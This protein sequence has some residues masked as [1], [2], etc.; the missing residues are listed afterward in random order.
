MPMSFQHMS[1]QHTER[2]QS[3]EPNRRSPAAVLADWWR[4]WTRSATHAFD[5]ADFSPGDIERIAQDVGLSGS[6]LQQLVRHNKDDA[7]LLFRRL[8]VQGLDPAAIDKADHATFLDLERV[9]TLCA[10][11]GRCKRDLASR[12]DDARWEDY[13]PNAATLKM[14]DAL[15]KSSMRESNAAR[16]VGDAP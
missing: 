14:L 1:L 2:N 4:D 9:C 16:V 6:D 12:P 5:F 15:A 8:A 10:C 11:K 3:R 7:E 13:C